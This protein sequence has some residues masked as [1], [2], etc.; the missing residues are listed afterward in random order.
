MVG[1]GVTEILSLVIRCRLGFGIFRQRGPRGPATEE[2]RERFAKQR[3]EA[4]EYHHLD[5]ISFM[6][7]R[8][9][10]ILEESGEEREQALVERYT[11]V[12]G[13]IALKDVYR[14]PL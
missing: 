7:A 6:T 5:E 2:Q 11:F 12:D 8:V 9:R 13:R 3:F 4:V 14:K 10:E 1:G